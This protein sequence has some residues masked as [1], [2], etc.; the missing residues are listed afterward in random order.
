M[1]EDL[2]VTVILVV[3]AAVLGL[4]IGSFLNVVIW[5]VPRGESVAHPPSACPR[6]GAG[7]KPYD[8]VPVLSW[9]LLRGRC[10]N[11]S[12]PISWRYPLIEAATAALF[13]AVVLW[14]GPVWSLPA[15]L[16]LVAITVALT[17]ID[18]DVKR[19][20]DAIVKPSYLVGAVLLTVAAYLSGDLSVMIRAL[21]G[22]AI[23]YVLYFVILFAYPPGMGWGDVKLAGV[24]GLY[25]GFLGWKEL[26]TG[27]F[28]AFLVGGVVSAAI[29]ARGGRKVKVP[30]GPFMLIGA[31][32]G[33]VVG[34]LL[35]DW[36]LN[37]T[38]LA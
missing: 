10:R 30:F 25:L 34:P 24:L 20:P 16:Y 5:R 27:A 28:L 18:I 29:M 7:I 12:E 26:A 9:L 11:C 31:W 1:S 38:N 19:L 14:F 32:C 4:A 35:A 22:M 37:I 3:L 13:V 21:I 8:N 2:E 6:C 15:F 23:M 33:V 36:Y 17:M